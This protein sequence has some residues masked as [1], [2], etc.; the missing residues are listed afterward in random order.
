MRF[1]ALALVFIM[2]A[3]CVM[4][5]CGDEQID[6][7]SASLEELDGLYGIG[8]VKAQ[9]IIDARPFETVD[10]LIN[11]YGIGE[12]TLKNI[13]NQGLACVEN[14]EQEEIIEE[15]IENFEEIP[16]EPKE[17]K[18]IETITL[19]T[20][21]IKS[22]E[23]KDKKSN[24]AIYGFVGFCVLLGILFAIKKGRYKNEFR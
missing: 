17:K 6:I 16:E 18:E 7:N 22:P 15:I 9:A 5:E 4:A 10:E 21:T 2:L 13:K 12:V 11:V 20:Q 24:Y 8:P 23:S 14:R 19:S 1:G 3:S